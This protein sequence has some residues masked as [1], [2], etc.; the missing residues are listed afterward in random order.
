MASDRMLL[1]V[2]Q[3]NC[4]AANPKP[5]D[6]AGFGTIGRVAEIEI[7]KAGSSRVRLDGIQRGKVLRLT[8]RD[9]VF[10]ATVQPIDPRPR[11]LGRDAKKTLDYAMDLFFGKYMDYC[12]AAGLP[13]Y[14][15]MHFA[16]DP[17]EAYK[18]GNYE[19]WCD[20]F[21][22]NLGSAVA[23]EKR[24]QLLETLS[25]SRRIKF[26]GE[27]LKTRIK[28]LAS[29]PGL[30]E[31]L[32]AERQR[33]REEASKAKLA[34]ETEIAAKL[35][36]LKKDI[37]GILRQPQATANPPTRITFELPIMP[38]RDVVVL[39]FTQMPF[40]VG[41]EFNL[42]ALNQALAADRGIFLATQHDA[43]VEE[44]RADEVYHFGMIV[45]ILETIK[46]PDNNVRVLVEGVQAA[47]AVQITR[48]DKCFRAVVEADANPQDPPSETLSALKTTWELV[49][50]HSLPLPDQQ[51]LLEIFSAD[52]PLNFIREALNMVVKARNSQSQ[53]S[54]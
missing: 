49:R 3:S 48:D 18:K 42:A 9:G 28:E 23:T 51:R 17:D 1:V 29:D 11:R 4:E 6:I 14:G 26:L 40:V 21:A 41:R 47:K 30:R 44:P 46:L 7:L 37:V 53:A 10:E 39:P 38:I 22:G 50:E 43:S 5:R 13:F 33:A 27:V 36:H 34:R 2:S 35:E 31:K 32:K 54:S 24:Q 52:G 45:H 20:V 12:E 15:M 25:P 19:V 16:V 8:R